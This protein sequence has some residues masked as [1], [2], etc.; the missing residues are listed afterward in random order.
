MEYRS[1]GRAGCMVSPL[2]LGTMLFGGDI[3]ADEAYDIVDRAIDAGINVI[4]TAN[5]YHSGTSEQVLG[6]ALKR[7]GERDHVVFAT[8]VH[9]VMDRDDPN[10]R[11][12]HR[13][14]IIR[15]CEAPLQRIE[16]ELIPFA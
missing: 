12:N 8:K 14:H 11:G 5:V 4:D 16:R 15:Q 13:Q 6:Q 10:G 1:V 9:G 7:N 3:P 2:C